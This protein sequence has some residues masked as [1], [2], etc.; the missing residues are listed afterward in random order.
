MHPY[1]IEN[2]D[3]AV[4]YLPPLDNPHLDQ[5]YIDLLK[6]LEGP[7]YDRYVLGKWGRP[8]GSYLK[9]D[10]LNWVRPTDIPERALTWLVGVDLAT[11]DD[12][13]HAEETDSNYY[14]AFVVAYDG[15]AQQAYAVDCHRVRGRR[16]DEAVQ[17]L[18]T[19]MGQL[20]RGTVAY[21]EANQAQDW[22]V[23]ACEKQ[24][25]RVARVQSFRNKEARLMALSIPAA[26]SKVQFVNHDD[27]NQYE[28][29]RTHDQRWD[30]FVQEWTG[31][32]TAHN[33]LLDGLD[34]ALAQVNLGLTIQAHMGRAYGEA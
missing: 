13:V 8:E 19:I 7:I 25:L 15:Q 23:Q 21:I 33:D 4:Y 6:S 27:P 34:I 9:Y 16:M 32:P 28:A 14:A 10:M 3:R 5:D 26:T 30:A 17:W 24:G 2:P 18:A 22:F 11:V 20:P 29:G 1:F 12:P 31:F